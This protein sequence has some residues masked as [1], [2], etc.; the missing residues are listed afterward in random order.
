MFS[1]SE[2]NFN[3]KLVNPIAKYIELDNNMLLVLA[4]SCR[5]VI[6]ETKQAPLRMGCSNLLGWLRVSKDMALFNIRVNQI[7]KKY[8]WI[9]SNILL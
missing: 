2:Y 1:V 3:R 9:Y 5:P 8:L 7:S 6:T 4:V